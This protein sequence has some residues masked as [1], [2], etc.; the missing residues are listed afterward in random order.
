MISLPSMLK[1]QRHLGLTGQWLLQ[2]V[3]RG[4][5]G[6]SAYFS[7]ILGWSGP[8]PET[9]GYLIPTLFALHNRFP[10]HGYD[11]AARHAGNWLLDI[12]HD[13]GAWPGGVHRAN[14]QGHPS[15]FNTGQVIRG[16]LA[17]DDATKD[18]GWLAAALRAAEWLAAGVGDDGQWQ[19]Q[20]YRSAN[21]PSYYT[22][23]ASPMLDV[24]R[25]TEDRGIHDASERVLDLVLRRRQTN[26][27]FAHWGF[28]EGEPG[29]THVIGYTVAGLLEAARLTGDWTRYGAPATQA[30]ETLRTKSELN[31][32]RLSGAFDLDWSETVKAVCLTGNAQI[33]ICLLVWEEQAH[34]LRLVNA[35]AKLM[36]EVCRRQ[37]V[38][39][40]PK[41]LRGAVG[42]SS[43]LWGRYMTM[44]YPNW[45]AK[46]HCDALMSLIDRLSCE[47]EST[48]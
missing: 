43:P 8:Y 35:A 5:P 39:S 47:V 41:S 25:R 2:S 18:N 14:R 32:G 48:T 38:H 31:H 16:L 42:G 4:N 7:P 34:D 26:G 19:L 24:W 40:W 6:S 37:W 29:F 36:D 33:A 20:D 3:A 30:L 44:R 11:Q 12:Q 21:T 10:D 28:A 1:Y 46:Y 9:T 15:V 22:Y 27:A 23:V 17:L 45:A 13:N